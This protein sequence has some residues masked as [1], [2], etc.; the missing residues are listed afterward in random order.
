MCQSH[1]WGYILKGRVRIRT[2]GDEFVLTTG[3]VYY[4]E[5]GHVPVFEEDTEVLE[6]SPK[7]EYQQTIDIFNK[8]IAAAQTAK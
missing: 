8:N 6:F 4:L 5:P 7:K 1:H 2:A 3:D